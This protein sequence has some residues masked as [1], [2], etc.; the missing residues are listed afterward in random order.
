MGERTDVPRLLRDAG[1]FVSS[2]LTEGISL[3]LLEAMAVGLPIVATAVGGNPEIVVAGKTG[4]LVPASDP[5]ALADAMI[6]M[7]RNQS[8]WLQMGKAGRD[9]VVRNFDV[10]RMASDYEHL[11]RNTS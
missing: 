7:C 1:F 8:S 9:R 3:T 4:S 10:H 2:S 5:R 11:Y 6:A